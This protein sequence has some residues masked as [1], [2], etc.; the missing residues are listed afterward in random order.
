MFNHEPKNYKCPFC[1]YVEDKSPHLVYSGKH[2]SAF[3]SSAQ[4]PKNKGIVIIIPNKHYENI[5]DIP[6]HILEKVH[7]LAKKVALTM[8]KTYKSDGVSMR[9][10][11]EP[12]GNQSIWHYHFQI[13]PRYNKDDLYVNHRKKTDIPEKERLKYAHLI[14][15]ELKYAK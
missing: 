8:K 15:R 2:L 6:D 9:Q 11:N 4:W 7:V 3:I 13:I 10:H 12:A 1:K 14:K 5:Y